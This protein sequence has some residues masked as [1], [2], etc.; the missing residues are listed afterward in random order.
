[1]RRKMVV[2]I[3]ALA[4][5]LIVQLGYKNWIAGEKIE[6]MNRMLILAADSLVIQNNYDEAERILNYCRATEVEHGIS[7]SHW[8][9]FADK[10]VRKFRAS[11]AFE[12]AKDDFAKGNIE[13]A[14]YKIHQSRALYVSTNGK[15]PAGFEAV[16]A[17][18][19]EAYKNLAM[20]FH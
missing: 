15:I 19:R 1:M 4:V 8:F 9:L 18:I 11:E 3:G 7:Q 14:W 20:G 16:E 13:K 6:D 2:A 12:K 17:D 10:K 5:I